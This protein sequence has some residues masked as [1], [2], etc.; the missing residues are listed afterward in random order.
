MAIAR[1]KLLVAGGNSRGEVPVSSRF[2][3][4]RHSFARIECLYVCINMGEVA[5]QTE[6]VRGNAI[7]STG[8]TR[9]GSGAC[10]S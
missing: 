2:S 6:P 9:D 3:R 5:A 4:E 1:E 8:S 7:T 10:K